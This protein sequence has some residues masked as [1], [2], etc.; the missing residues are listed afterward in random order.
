V[1]DALSHY[2]LPFISLVVV[3]VGGQAVGMRSMAIY[4][5]GTDYV[6]YARGLGVNDGRVVKYIFR[7]AMLPQVTGLALS[8]GTL[9]GSALITEVVF[10]YPGVGTLLFSAIRQNDYPIIQ[11]ITLLITIAVLT[12]NFLIDILYGVIDPRIRAAQSG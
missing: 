6:N 9:V 12:M 10:S 3:F 11:G 2:F 1:L 7:N 5:L 8:L 4:E